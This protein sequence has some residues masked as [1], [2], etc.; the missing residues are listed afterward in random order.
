MLSEPRVLLVWACG[1]KEVLSLPLPPRLIRRRKGGGKGAPL[2]PPA[3][4][5]GVGRERCAKYHL[6]SAQGGLAHVEVEQ[7][8][9]SPLPK[10]HVVPS[11]EL[12][13]PDMCFNKK[14]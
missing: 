1:S 4:A 11:C 10:T 8:P 14:Q 6:L 12:V 2:T 3:S 13:K 7:L 5:R 9:E